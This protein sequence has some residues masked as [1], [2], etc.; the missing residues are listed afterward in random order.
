[1]RKDKFKILN[2]KQVQM[3][4][5]QNNKQKTKGFG[6][7]NFDILICLEFRVLGLLKELK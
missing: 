4:K 1:M 5:T 7:F 3:T 2:P 6:N